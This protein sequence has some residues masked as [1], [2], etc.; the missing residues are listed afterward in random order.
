MFPDLP[1]LPAAVL[2]TRVISVPDDGLLCL[3]LGHKSVASENTLEK[4]IYFLNAKGLEPIAQSEEHLVVK[5]TNHIP[6]DTGDI[7]VGIPHHICPTVALYQEVFVID[8]EKIIGSWE[9]V[10]RKRKI[11]F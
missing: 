4:R 7:L 8:N 6:L 1:F 11:N 3:D 2:I 9:V 10:A 5:N